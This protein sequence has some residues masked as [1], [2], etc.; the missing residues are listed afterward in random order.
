MS[1]VSVFSP[2][3]ETE[4]DTIVALLEARAVPCFVRDSACAPAVWESQLPRRAK[5]TIMVPAECLGAAVT[6]IGELE[7]RNAAET[8]AASRS[9]RRDLRSLLRHALAVCLPGVKSQPEEPPA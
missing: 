3:T 1:L 5:R 7:R 2:R 4:L 9:V 8:G 6:L